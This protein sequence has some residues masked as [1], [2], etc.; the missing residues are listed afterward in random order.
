M[1]FDGSF[2]S[3]ITAT[4]TL[5]LSNTTSSYVSLFPIPLAL[6]CRTLNV[7][8]SLI[9]SADGAGVGDNEGGG[10]GVDDCCSIAVLRASRGRR[11]NLC[12]SDTVLHLESRTFRM[13]PSRTFGTPVAYSSI[14]NV[15]GTYR[16]VILGS[17]L[18]M[19]VARYQKEELGTVLLLT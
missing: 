15:S 7:L 17:R 4:L 18:W 6:N 19:Y 12:F 16:A 11:S 1:D 8:S 13:H 5:F 3:C 9:S 14:S 10:G 2:E